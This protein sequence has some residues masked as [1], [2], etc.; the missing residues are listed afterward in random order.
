MPKGISCKVRGNWT[1]GREG[2]STFKW[3][4]EIKNKKIPYRVF[5]AK[6]MYNRN[7]GNAYD[8]SGEKHTFIN[9]RSVWIMREERGG[10][11]GARFKCR[12]RLC[13]CTFNT[14][15]GVPRGKKGNSLCGVPLCVA[16]VAFIIQRRINTPSG[17][18]RRAGGKRLCL[19]KWSPTVRREFVKFFPDAEPRWRLSSESREP[20]GMDEAPRRE[21][22]LL[23]A[24]GR[25]GERC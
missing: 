14:R 4:V 11:G 12:G 7:R 10:G 16:S 20:A 9:R 15:V 1:K 21:W 6:R 8:E 25:E 17:N 19:R 23:D 18:R 3:I 22:K 24:T 2:Q 13:N 5:L